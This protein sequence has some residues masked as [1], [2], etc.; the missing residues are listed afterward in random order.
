VNRRPGDKR[1]SIE[2]YDEGEIYYLKRVDIRSKYLNP[3]YIPDSLNATGYQYELE[4]IS[5]DHK[6]ITEF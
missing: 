4:F 3:Q 5:K 2:T 6:K 1:K